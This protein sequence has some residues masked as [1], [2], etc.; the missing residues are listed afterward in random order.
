MDRPLR[1]NQDRNSQLQASLFPA[2]NAGGTLT[3]V[4]SARH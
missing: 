4:S 3:L 1:S 2:H